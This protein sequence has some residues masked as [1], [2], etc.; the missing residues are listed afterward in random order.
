VF[1]AARKLVLAVSMLLI[2]SAVLADDELPLRDP[3]QPYR[4]IP[5][6]GG[7]DSA[8]RSLDLSAVLVSTSRRVAVINGGL[9]RV[10]DEIDG[11][12]LVAIDS[13]SVRL[14]RGGEVLVLH[15]SRGRLSAGDN[16]GEPAQ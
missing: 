5:S 4:R 15:L 13:D 11:A 6:N 1:D 2:A 12:T 3:M 10:G 7:T 16:E 8:P 9:R 14:R